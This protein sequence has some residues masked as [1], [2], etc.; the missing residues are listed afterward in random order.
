MNFL[1]FA[2]MLGIL[3]FVHEL[4]H[5]AVAKRLGVPVLE[6]GFGFPPR[7]WRF[8]KDHGWI[9][10]QGRRIFVPREF[11]LPENLLVGTR[12]TYKTEMR[13]ERETLT[14]I[15]IVDDESAGLVMASPV[16]N[17]DRGTE[18]TVNWIPL[19]GF[20]RLLGEEDPNVPGGFGMAK[21]RVRIAVLIAGVTMNF[22]LA[23]VLLMLVAGLVPQ[24]MSASTTMLAAVA[25]DS[26][27]ALAGLQA[28]DVVVAV[29]AQPIKD[30]ADTLIKLTR[31]YAGQA[32]T[33]E[34]LRGTQMLAPVQMT[35]RVTPPA[36]QGPL[37]ISLARSGVRVSAVEP[38]S[39]MERAGVRAGDGA[40]LLAGSDL[41]FIYEQNALAQFVQTHP[42]T[43]FQMRII[44]DGKVGDPVIVT[45]PA[46]VNASNAT[47][48]LDL[49]TPIWDTPRIATMQIGQIA[50]AIP[51]LFSQAVNGNLPANSFVGVIGIYQA[52]G[53]V[54][55]I[56]GAV[57]LI[58][59]LALLSLNLA[60][61]NLFPFPPLDGGQLVYILVEWL[62]GGK[63]I[64]PK[65]QGMV[66][67]IGMVVLLG[68]MIIISYFDVLRWISGEPILPVR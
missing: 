19:G 50:L 21:M 20:V 31:Q 48:G 4:G 6:F 44:R 12:V 34:V 13:G 54:A 58:N 68:L 27:A 52:T 7:L 16:Q 66:Q 29:N 9:E 15:A 38:G 5:F 64:D 46:Q 39:V 56:A 17:L 65:R 11:Q 10:I 35:P 63:R 61:V 3:I 51:N 53:E 60:I 43:S 8:W 2:A 32:V 1:I 67:L 28:G 42:G 37:G 49:R 40:M 36:N 41:G 22:I 33:F 14:G 62:R 47:L 23:Y 25:A 59:W 26:P 18:Y 30:D 57:G 24:S 55:R 45:I